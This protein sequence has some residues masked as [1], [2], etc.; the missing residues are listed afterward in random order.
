MYVIVLAWETQTV[1]GTMLD[2]ASGQTFG[3]ML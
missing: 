2:R 1:L 3:A